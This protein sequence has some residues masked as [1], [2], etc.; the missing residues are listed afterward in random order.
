MIEVELTFDM[1]SLMSLEETLTA[2]LREVQIQ[3]GLSLRQQG[4][5]IMS[6]SRNQVPE[7]TGTLA[8]AGF[9]TTDNSG[10]EESVRIGYDGTAIN[11]KTGQSVSEYIMA[12]HERLDVYHPKGNAKFFE[13]PVLQY[14]PRFEPMLAD[15]LAKALLG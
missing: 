9:V 1:A 6:E 15:M 12:V 10:E 7:D 5:A 8:E 4:E 14:S 3:G 13:Q 2:K 11:P